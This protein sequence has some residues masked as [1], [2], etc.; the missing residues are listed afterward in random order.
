MGWWASVKQAWADF[1][2]FGESAGEARFPPPPVLPRDDPQP[3]PPPRAPA[4][5]DDLASELRQIRIEA[6]EIRWRVGCLLVFLI[7]GVLVGG[8]LEFA[9]ESRRER[10]R[11]LIESPSIR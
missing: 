4:T 2:R 11:D 5:V 7:V 8:C 3:M 6:A 9:A 1:C 10:V